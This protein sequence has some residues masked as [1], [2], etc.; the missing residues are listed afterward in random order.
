MPR[1]EHGIV[2]ESPRKAAPT[3]SWCS[4]VKPAQAPALKVK[5][6]AMGLVTM[7]RT[8]RFMPCSLLNLKFSPIA[9]RCDESSSA[10]DNAHSASIRCDICRAT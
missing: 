3:N 8:H 4:N 10:S 6:E 2:R 7:R 1:F 9:A 5:L